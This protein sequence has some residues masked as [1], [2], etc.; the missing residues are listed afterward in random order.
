MD[1]A[2]HP[3]G[4]VLLSHLTRLCRQWPLRCP[5]SPQRLQ[6]TYLLQAKVLSFLNN[7][8]S[9]NSQVSYNLPFT[10]TIKSFP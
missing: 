4:S 1:P 9:E 8:N 2:L 5:Y 3:K 10:P 6:A 7:R